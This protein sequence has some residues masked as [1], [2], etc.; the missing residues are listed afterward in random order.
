M[1]NIFDFID[2]AFAEGDNLF[3]VK[4]IS[5]F[6]RKT[7]MSAYLFAPENFHIFLEFALR[8]TPRTQS[9]DPGGEQLADDLKYVRKRAPKEAAEQVSLIDDVL[10]NLGAEAIQPDTVESETVQASSV[11]APIQISVKE[12]VQNNLRL[13]FEEPD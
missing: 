2:V 5:N 9:L 7:Y 6:I 12:T 1:S 4:A 3:S 13:F 10:A 11:A 8:M